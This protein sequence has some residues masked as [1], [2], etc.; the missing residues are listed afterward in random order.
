MADG[1]RSL[2][3]WQEVALLVRLRW[4][5]QRNQLR[6]KNARFELAGLILTS[7]FLALIV[8]VFAIILEQ[9]AAAM[10]REGRLNWLALL[11]W[12]VLLFWQ[13][14]SILFASLTTLFDFRALL[15]F[16]LHV[17]AFFVMNVAYGAAD[18]VAIASLIWLMAI[19]LGVASAR[20]ELSPAAAAVII[21]FS[22]LN[23]LAE[24]CI[25]SWIERLLSKRR[26]RELTFAVLILCI[27]SVQFIVPLLE[28]KRRSVLLWLPRVLP[29]LSALPPGLAGR[30]VAA[31][32]NG[33]GAGFIVSLAGLAVYCLPFAY[34][35]W[36]QLAA[37]FCGELV[38]ESEGGPRVT[39]ATAKAPAKA[40]SPVLEFLAGEIAA[41]VQ[42]ELRYLKR[43]GI[44]WMNLLLPFLFIL[45]FTLRPEMRRPSGQIEV[46]N[47]GSEW[48][49]FSAVGYVLLFL[50]APSYNA[51]AY[52]GRGIQTYFTAPVHFR[53]VLLGKNLV[54]LLL[55]VTEVSAAILLL[56]A[57][58]TWP[59][60]AQ[61][62]VTL[63]AAAYVIPAQFT[64]ANWASVAYP[65]KLE[66]GSMRN[67]RASGM[68]MLI[69]LGA[70]VVLAA[71]SAFVIL[72]GH[73]FGSAWVSAGAFLLLAAGAI[74][75]YFA[76]LDAL[77]SLAEKKREVLL[78]ALCK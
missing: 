55:I 22:L 57:R 60:P 37:Q 1:T 2:T 29:F 25:G 30:A 35:L 10:T 6:Q 77:S 70:Y 47:R 19:A 44:A 53:S 52:E 32:G 27:V 59:G 14:F 15:R 9:A 26:T 78:D 38:F 21:V 24:R 58:G 74:G 73:W 50:L 65:R 48:F 17:R 67:Q 45:I 61:L 46:L 31:A 4:R 42:K 51:F 66:F 18:P 3:L 39:R 43:N 28:G 36:R 33:Q 75:G 68:T 20:P 56:G 71:S 69:M 23:I 49:F 16:P 62:A 5:I 76:S 34:L 8:A 64:M 40:D 41:V 63:A 12:A 54:V 11:F 13:F 7:L 72:A